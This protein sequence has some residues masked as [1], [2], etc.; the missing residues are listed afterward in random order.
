ME[1]GGT[2]G[3]QYKSNTSSSDQSL[4]GGVHVSSSYYNRK[5][6]H[7]F[8]LWSGS[9]IERKSNSVTISV[10]IIHY[11]G[12]DINI[13]TKNILSLMADWGEG[14]CMGVTKKISL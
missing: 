5:I 13:D 7:Q 12:C 10:C 11:G 3:D 8:D 2:E 9:S 6:P 1:N 14:Y 4:I